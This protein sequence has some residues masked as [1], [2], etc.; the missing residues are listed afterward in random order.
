MPPRPLPAAWRDRYVGGMRSRCIGRVE[1]NGDNRGQLVDYVQTRNGGQLGEYYCMDT[2]GATGLDMFGKAWPLLLSG[3]CAQQRVYAKKKGALRTRA[4]FD[5][6]RAKDPLLV[7]GWILLVIDAKGTPL[8]EE[9]AAGLQGHAHH[10]G[11]VGDV[12]DE[13]GALVVNGTRGGFLTCEG[14]AADPK[15][16]SSRNGDGMYHGRERG[17]R[18]DATTYE[19]IDPSAFAGGVV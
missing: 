2:V 6:L 3:S 7:A 15:K 8:P 17:H 9:K 12:D 18:D 14:N 10:T 1:P 19:F 4:E 13:S 5:A 11:T 16:P